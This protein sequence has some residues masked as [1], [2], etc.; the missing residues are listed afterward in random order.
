MARSVPYL[1][2]MLAARLL[3]PPDRP[4][5]T[6]FL[7]AHA[8]ITMFL[9][10]NLAAVG[11]VD[12]PERF[13]G[14]WAGAFDGTELVGVATL[15]WNGMLNVAAP[16]P[17]GLALAARA[18]VA[19]APRKLEGLIGPWQQ[20]VGA[21]HALGLHGRA[22]R[23]C[24][25]DELYLLALDALV[26][27]DFGGRT[28]RRAVAGDVPVLARWRRDYGIETLGDAPDIPETNA[29]R[30]VETAIAA[31]R[32][33]V[34]C[35]DD[36]PAAMT[37]F[38]ATTGDSVQVGGVFTPEAARGRG[39]ARIAVAGSLRD[40]RAEGARTA[41]LFTGED[42]HPARRAYRALGF[43]VVGDYGMIF[44]AD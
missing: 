26:V 8:P 18:A 33:W 40:A 27:P 35:E 7:E 5:V 43:A 6:R 28:V 21:R 20:I 38:N 36:V 4:T 15:F 9:R 22:M 32:T 1:S 13:Q 11:L 44:F 23:L 14:T 42:N 29:L 25:K 17:L 34:V 30:E 19:G 12:G 24:K 2:L 31:A 37:T 3:K 10:S 41:V 39:L 16:A